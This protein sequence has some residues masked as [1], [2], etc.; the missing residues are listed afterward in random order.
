MIF[1]MPPIVSSLLLL[2]CRRDLQ[3][4]WCL[5]AVGIRLPATYLLAG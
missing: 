4:R 1:L 3:P 2:L 5:I